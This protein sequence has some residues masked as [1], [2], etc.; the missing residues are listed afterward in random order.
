MNKHRKKL[1]AHNI[2]NTVLYIDYIYNHKE[3]TNNVKR[4]T[5]F[6]KVIFISPYTG[7]QY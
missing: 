2:S 1:Y 6:T 5:L 7:N 4:F 3:T